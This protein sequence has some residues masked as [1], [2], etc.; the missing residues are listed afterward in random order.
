MGGKCDKSKQIKKWRK[1]GQM[2]N[3]RSYG[4]P[5]EGSVNDGDDGGKIRGERAIVRSTCR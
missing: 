4:F 5:Q 2:E 3:L 1:E